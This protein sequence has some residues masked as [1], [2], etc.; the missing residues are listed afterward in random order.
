MDRTQ[1]LIDFCSLSD[2]Q[3]VVTSSVS[4][5]TLFNSS[6]AYS[7]MLNVRS[8]VS[9]HGMQ[10][11]RTCLFKTIDLTLIRYVLMPK[12]TETICRWESRELTPMAH[13]LLRTH[14]HSRVVEWTVPC[15]TP[16]ETTTAVH[17][18]DF[19][20][21]LAELKV[22]LVRVARNNQL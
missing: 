21:S 6:F 11:T 5:C 15:E 20:L 4:V 12:Q 1:I 19:Q 7:T 2:P 9:P 22:S 8:P 13:E 3:T 14:F 17:G 10:Q 18:L 16:G